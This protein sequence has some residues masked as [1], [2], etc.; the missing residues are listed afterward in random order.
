MKQRIADALQIGGGVGL[1]ASAWSVSAALGLFV[2][3]VVL[4]VAGLVVAH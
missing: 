3:S 2:G 1:T 4:I